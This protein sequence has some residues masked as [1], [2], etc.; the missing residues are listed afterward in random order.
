MDQL[1]LS[2]KVDDATDEEIAEI[3]REIRQWIN[4]NVPDCR[5]S[6]GQPAIAR[7][8][9]KGLDLGLLAPITLVFLQSGALKELV[10]CLTT[11]VKER[12]RKVSLSVQNQA[13]K[14]ISIEAENLG[15][16]ELERIMQQMREIA[17]AG[18]A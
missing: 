3:N 6:S 1:E 10:N 7:A 14:S 12:R 4:E 17:G 13:G 9:E 2:V 11:Y 8:G 15:K 18:P 16:Q 5:I